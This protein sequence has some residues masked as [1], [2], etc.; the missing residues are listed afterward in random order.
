MRAGLHRP[1]T[2]LMSL[3]GAVMLLLAAPAQAQKRTQLPAL[4]SG[5]ISAR[6]SVHWGLL[7]L[8]EITLTWQ[9][10]ETDFQTRMTART[11]GVVR[12]VFK[13]D[14][15]LTSSGTRQN[16]VLQS[17]N[18]TTDS[19]FNGDTFVRE[20]TFEPSGQG[21]ITRRVRPDDYDVVR[22]P[23]PIDLQVGPDPLTAFLETM[24]Q[25]G[26]VLQSRSYDGVQVLENTLECDTSLETLKKKRRS[27]F[28]GQAQRCTLTGDVLAGDIV[29]EDAASDADED[30]DG[31]DFETLIWFARTADGALRLP[32]RVRAQSKR[33]TLKIHL[34]DVGS[35]LES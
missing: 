9:V 30:V 3:A 2:Q 33:G 21:I 5:S 32:V 34:R 29:E 27:R 11:R 1:A 7:R 15:L 4:E 18:F 16:D 24:L 23:V 17:T 25:P 31:R 14:S 19:V 8:A 22:A 26:S 28:Y 6:Y 20:M 10:T 13:A 35:D 12:A